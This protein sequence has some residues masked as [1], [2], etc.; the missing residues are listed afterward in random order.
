[1]PGNER[2]GM[3]VA[4]EG[5]I[6]YRGVIAGALHSWAAPATRPIISR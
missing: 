4:D 2:R 5:V 6:G 1:V 3:T